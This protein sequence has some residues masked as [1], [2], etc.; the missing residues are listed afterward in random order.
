MLLRP[1]PLTFSRAAGAPCSVAA[2]GALSP[3]QRSGPRPQYNKGLPFVILWP[4]SHRLIYR[5]GKRGQGG[6]R[7]KQKKGRSD[8]EEEKGNKNEGV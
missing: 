8:A 7:R 5:R 3:V 4:R 6:K 1:G 2:T